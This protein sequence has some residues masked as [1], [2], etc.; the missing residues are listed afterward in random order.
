AKAFEEACRAGDDVRLA[1]AYWLL[2][3]G[4]QAGAQYV[5]GLD[6]AAYKAFASGQQVAL[7]SSTL[8]ALVTGQAIPRELWER[9]A[10]PEAALITC[11]LTGER[12]KVTREMLRKKMLPAEPA[13]EP[14]KPTEK[15]RAVDG[16]TGRPIEFDEQSGQ[17]RFSK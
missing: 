8:R 16:A 17:W 10:Y 6:A 5:L 11:Y 3:K 15:K 4:D 13:R 14:D 9:V 1:I 12:A 2:G 7:G